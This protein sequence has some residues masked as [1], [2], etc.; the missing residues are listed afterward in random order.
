MEPIILGYGYSKIDEQG[1]TLWFRGFPGF[2]DWESPISMREAL[3][4]GCIFTGI[5]NL[6]NCLFLYKADSSGNTQFLRHYD[7]TTQGWDVACL[8]DGVI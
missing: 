7:F 2:H 8:R 1:D 4:G 6:S 3:D 5:A